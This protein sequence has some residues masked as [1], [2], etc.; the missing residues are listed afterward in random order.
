MRTECVKSVP[1]RARLAVPERTIRSSLCSIAISRIVETTRLERTCSSLSA[2]GATEISRSGSSLSRLPTQRALTRAR[3][4]PSKMSETSALASRMRCST[5]PV[6][7]MSTIMT[8]RVPRLTNS[9]WRT[10]ERVSE[11]YCTT[12]TWRVI[13]E[14]KRTVRPM[15]SSR[16]TAPS[17]KDSIALRSAAES[18]FTPARRSTKRR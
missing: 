17:R 6:S 2:R 4:S 10:V 1:S 3:N 11:G 12:A 7:V 5:R 8:R 15:T 14:S 16:S 18:G 13:C 9:M